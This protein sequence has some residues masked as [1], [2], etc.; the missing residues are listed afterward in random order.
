MSRSRHEWD[1]IF[2]QSDSQLRRSRV[3]LYFLILHR[4][5]QESSRR[6]TK[7][8]RWHKKSKYI[9]SKSWENVMKRKIKESNNI[10]NNWCSEFHCDE[11]GLWWESTQRST[12]GNCF[13]PRKKR[14][15][16]RHNARWSKCWISWSERRLG[17][18]RSDGRDSKRCLG[19]PRN[20]DPTTMSSSFPHSSHSIPSSHRALCSEHI[21]ITRTLLSS[22]TFTPIRKSWSNLC[23]TTPTLRSEIRAT[24]L[25]DP[26]TPLS[27]LG[28]TGHTGFHVWPIRDQSLQ[29]AYHER[30]DSEV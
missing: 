10:P 26:A 18:R 4:K 29:T 1:L 9:W 6:I 14:C 15:V 5:T 30:F 3:E 20:S 19:G 13:F 16:S 7:T 12:T 17:K 24:I 11:S 2:V 8:V 23:L 28:V 25:S 27:Y 22:A 21:F